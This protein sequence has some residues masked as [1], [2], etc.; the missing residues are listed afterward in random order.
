MEFTKYHQS[1]MYYK[2]TDIVEFCKTKHAEMNAMLKRYK[3]NGVYIRYYNIP[4]SFDIETTAFEKNGKEYSYC[5]LWQFNIDGVVFIGRSLREF[6]NFI[7][8]LNNGLRLCE[9]KRLIV[10]V[11]NLAYEF[12]FMKDLF[13]WKEI[14]AL[15]KYKPIRAVVSDFDIEFRCSYKLSNLSLATL[16]E[17]TKSKK[18]VGDLDYE[19]L[20]HSKTPLTSREMKYAIYDTEVVVE[21]IRQMID[22]YGDLHNVP[23][24]S[25][26]KV[27]KAVKT[28][29]LQSKKY[30]YAVQDIKIKTDEELTLI[31]RAFTGGFTHGNY[32]HVGENCYNVT[33]YDLTS[34][35]PSRI[36]CSYF[37][38]SNGRKV[39]IKSK[40]H[41]EY[42]LNNNCCIFEVKFKK[43]ESKISYEHFLSLHKCYG[44]V[45][46]TIDN[47]RIVSA[48]TLTTVI[49]EVDLNILKQCYE[50]EKMEIGVCYVYKRG[51]LPKEFI[52]NVLE[53]YTLKTT[54]K[55]VDGKEKQYALYKTYVNALYGCMVTKINNPEIE[56]INGE[57]LEHEKSVSKILDDYNNN[58]TRFLCY[59]WGVYVTAHAR[60]ILWQ[61]IFELKND[62]IYADTDSV[63]FFNPDKHKKFFEKA[64]TDIINSLKK[65]CLYTGIDFEKCCP[66]T[67]KGIEKPL[68]VWDF[69]GGYKVFKTLGAKRYITISENNELNITIAGL[70]KNQGKLYFIKKNGKY[71][72]FSAFSDNLYINAGDTGKLTHKYID[73][74]ETVKTTLTDYNG[75]SDEVLINSCVYLT[76]AP[77]T[78][79]LSE[80]FKKFLQGYRNE[81]QGI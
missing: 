27:R 63:K 15:S 32:N 40:K 3:K 4:V 12:Q 70:S 79:Q 18:L 37:P 10:F 42:L 47:G 66:K 6:L 2:S 62:Y 31:Q 67:V 14:F 53:W 49:T 46:P 52:E 38:M 21:Y 45:K 54:L 56:L 72:A 36:C 5:Y 16:S 68:G 17:F 30:K 13:E 39:K 76:G 59:Q 51:Y 55:G 43:I 1:H 11:H 61:A 80:L 57:W 48:E 74:K 29:V 9:R 77:F 78:L 41:F 65:M 50:W 73:L 64:N 24:T 81:V 22:E 28:S 20:R 71:G 23:L 75:I 69:D 26:G 25:T 44:V 34:S 35:Y 33:S 19:K 8:K 60:S 7:Q 58:G